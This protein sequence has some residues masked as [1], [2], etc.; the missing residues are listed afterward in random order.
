MGKGHLPFAHYEGLNKA[1]QSVASGRTYRRATRNKLKRDSYCSPIEWGDDIPDTSS[2]EETVQNEIDFKISLSCLRGT[3]R[4]I[5][6]EKRN[7]R[8]YREIAILLGLPE[9]TVRRQYR[10][11]L[12]QLRRSLRKI[13]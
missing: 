10:E 2:L 4:K 13:N 9:G 11:A 3:K 8:T 7:Q 6:A 1:A 12:E 5:V